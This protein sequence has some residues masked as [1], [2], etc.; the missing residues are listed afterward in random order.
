MQASEP[1]LI[2]IGV[3]DS[4]WREAALNSISPVLAAVLGGLIVSLIIQRVQDRRSELRRGEEYQRSELRREE[5]S[6]RSEAER[7]AQL[8]LDIMKTAFDFYTRRIEAARV[9][10]YDGVHRIE[11]GALP[12]HYQDFRIAARVLEEQ[13]RVYLPGGEARWLWHG[14]VDILSLRYYRLVHKGPRFDGM[15]KTHGEHFTEAKIPVVIRGMFSKP[16]DLELKDRVQFH[17]MVMKKFEDM[18]TAL[19]NI[20]VHGQLDWEGDPVVLNPGGGPGLASMFRDLE[21]RG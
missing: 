17:N 1:R 6:Q 12:R 15:K 9:E 5:E 2:I 4:F 3:A 11:L 18:L 19:I 8:G 7:R 13:L 20:V 14:A 16:E 21:L 10:E